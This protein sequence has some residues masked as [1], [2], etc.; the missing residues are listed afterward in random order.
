MSRMHLLNKRHRQYFKKEIFEFVIRLFVHS[1]NM[2][3]QQLTSHG[4]GPTPILIRA[5]PAKQSVQ[6]ITPRDVYEYAQFMT[7]DH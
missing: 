4:G 6:V 7:T 1:R 5:L 3:E 2:V